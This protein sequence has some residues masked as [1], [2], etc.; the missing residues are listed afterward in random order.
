MPE[1]VVIVIRTPLNEHWIHDSWTTIRNA[2][3]ILRIA[4]LP[5]KSNK[6]EGRLINLGNLYRHARTICMR[7][8]A[9]KIGRKQIS[10][11]NNQA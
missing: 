10:P 1:Q 6:C 11:K 8:K 5:A 7:K 9:L 3:P 2:A 4:K